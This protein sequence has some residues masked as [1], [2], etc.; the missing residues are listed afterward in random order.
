MPRKGERR[1]KNWLNEG[2]PLWLQERL[3]ER[4]WLAVDLAKKL[5]VDAGVISNYM[6]GK[7]SPDPKLLNRIA[8]VMGVSDEEVFA[9]AGYLREYEPSEDPRQEELCNRL[10][11]I[12]LTPERYATLSVLLESWQPPRP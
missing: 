5:A 2:F 1:Y 3:G 8:D 9:A 10:H 4:D 11:G 6:S 7:R 12:D